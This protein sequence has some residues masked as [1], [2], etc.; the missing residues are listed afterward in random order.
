MSGSPP[1]EPGTT[2]WRA[3]HAIPEVCTG[4]FDEDGD[5][6]IDC[7]DPDC[8]TEPNLDPVCCTNNPVFDLDDD[9]TWI[10]RTLLCSKFATT[11]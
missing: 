8:T 1:K 11:R 3:I 7:A 5:G 9:E 6:L 4:G 2:Q 10:S